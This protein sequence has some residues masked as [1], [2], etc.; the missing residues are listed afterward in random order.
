MEAFMLIFS[1]AVAAAVLVT[2][3]YLALWSSEH[4]KTSKSIAGFGRIMAIIMF[5]FAGLGLL[6]GVAFSAK[7]GMCELKGKDHG[8]MM[9]K[10][11]PGKGMGEIMGKGHRK[12]EMRESLKE[13]KK[14]CFL[15]A[16]K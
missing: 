3:G 8:M 10:M 14:E 9:K 16:K 6:M 11:H 13:W 5:V 7:Y 2:L 1:A 15:L 4:E 12:R